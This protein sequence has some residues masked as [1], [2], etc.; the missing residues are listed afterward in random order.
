MSIRFDA[1][2]FDSGGTIWNSPEPGTVPRGTSIVEG[3]ERRA[4]RLAHVLESLGYAV[5]HA[6]LQAV[7]PALEETAPQRFGE[8]YTYVNLMGAVSAALGI[9][10][11]NED[12]FLCA[13]SY[14]GVRYR[15]CLFPG[16]EETLRILS[17]A[18]LHLGMISNTYIPG[19]AVDR[20]LRSVGLLQYLKTRIYSGDEGVSKPDPRIFKL[21]EQRAGLPGKR[22]LYVGDDVKND[23]EAARAVGWTAALRLAARPSGGG[24]ADFAF[25]HSSEL[26]PFILAR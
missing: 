9:A 17:E 2:F 26:L 6:K 24:S 12:A 3:W 5:D 1:V 7:L 19:Y 14:V 23:I 25:E 20:L 16:T 22:I 11:R 15:C 13:D 8:S 10:L 4:A 18:G 21:A